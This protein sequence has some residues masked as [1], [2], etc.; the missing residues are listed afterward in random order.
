MLIQQLYKILLDETIDNLN[1][2]FINDDVA[3]INYN[4]KDQFIDNSNSINVFIAC[5][6]SHARLMSVI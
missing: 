6:T 4:Y 2:Q 5:F 3:Q 1:I